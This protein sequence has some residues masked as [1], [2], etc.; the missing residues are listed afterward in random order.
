MDGKER[1]TVEKGFGGKE[2]MS[3]TST[4]YG[5]RTM[6]YKLWTMGNDGWIDGLAGRFKY[7]RNFCSEGQV[8]YS[9]RYA[10]ESSLN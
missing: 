3:S 5:L 7:W 6:D 10:F 9:G 1:S 8:Q 2:I 4:V